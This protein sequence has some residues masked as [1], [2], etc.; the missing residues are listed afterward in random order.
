[1]GGNLIKKYDTATKPYSH[2]CKLIEFVTLWATL[3]LYIP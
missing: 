2:K 1:M 3:L